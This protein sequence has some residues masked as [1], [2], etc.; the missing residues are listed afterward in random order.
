MARKNKIFVAHDCH[1]C[2]ARFLYFD[3]TNC[4]NFPPTWAYCK[5]CC[6]ELGI[7]FNK[8]YPAKNRAINATGIGIN[9]QEEGLE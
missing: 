8:Q 4:Q 3:L 5:K 6:K 7:D 9:E 1:R 2:G